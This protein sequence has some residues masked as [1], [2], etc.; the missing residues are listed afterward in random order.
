M[1][2]HC[3]RS[4]VLIEPGYG[5]RIV[6]AHGGGLEWSTVVDLVTGESLLVPLTQ[7]SSAEDDWRWHVVAHAPGWTARVITQDRAESLAE[8]PEGILPRNTDGAE[9]YD[10]WADKRERDPVMRGVMKVLIRHREVV[11]Y[12][13]DWR[14]WI[15][16]HPTCHA[17]EENYYE[18][19]ST[20]GTKDKPW[21]H[22]VI[23][24][25]KRRLKRAVRDPTPVCGS[26]DKPYT[27]GG[28]GYLERFASLHVKPDEKA[29]DVILA[30]LRKSYEHEV[31]ARNG[32]RPQYRHGRSL[33]PMK[34]TRTF[35]QMLKVTGWTK[36][37]LAEIDTE[38]ERERARLHKATAHL[39]PEGV[40]LTMFDVAA[41]EPES[42]E[43]DQQEELAA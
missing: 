7:T 12:I 1:S 15:F 25:P 42:D 38:V 32:D 35:E 9:A 40:Q 13:V 34:P 10:P 33:P 37:V 29:S 6:Q 24:E 27:Q 8:L 11:Y 30:D 14:A 28:G 36:T 3:Y 39:L 20:K 16:D 21:P 26:M 23:V 4:Y 41:V 19:R 18:S 31:W 5:E 17:E 43:D 22:T 2:L